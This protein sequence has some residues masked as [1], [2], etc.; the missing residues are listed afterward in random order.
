MVTSGLKCIAGT[1]VEI[2]GNIGSEIPTEVEQ[3]GNKSSTVE[4]TGGWGS[5]CILGKRT[6]LNR[7]ADGSGISTAQ[8][9][10]LNNLLG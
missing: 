4:S 9:D 2:K 7:S 5:H 10:G 3:H 1:L 6:G 8:A